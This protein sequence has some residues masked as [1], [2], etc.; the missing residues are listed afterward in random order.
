MSTFQDAKPAFLWDDHS[1]RISWQGDGEY[2]AVSLINL[3]S[4]R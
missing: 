3:R 1:V 4:G 2:F